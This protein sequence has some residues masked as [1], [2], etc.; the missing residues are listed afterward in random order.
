MVSTFRLLVLAVLFYLGWVLL[1][2]AETQAH[3]E[4]P[5]QSKVVLLYLATASVGVGI[6]ALIA[7]MVVPA[8]GNF[9]GNRIFN[10]GGELA[11]DP[12][13]EATAKVAREDYEGAIK[14]YEAILWKDPSD[15]LALSE[16]A[17]ICCRD[18]NDPIR[19]AIVIERAL[20]HEW[21]LEQSSFLANRLADIYLL[22]EEPHRARDVLTQVAETMEGT[23]YARNAEHRV[24]E[25]DRAM[26]LGGRAAG[27]LEDADEEPS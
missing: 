10:P 12:H 25:I 15:T 27:Q 7:T 8:L 26:A 14:D 1:S 23:K 16:I 24:Q 4:S 20:A 21:P 3:L 2:E 13:T 19:A 18:L 5:D 22:R 11:L 17:R 9:I 6:A